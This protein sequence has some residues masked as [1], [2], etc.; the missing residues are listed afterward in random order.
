M[1]SSLPTGRKALLVERPQNFGLR[2]QAHVADFVEEQRA[3]VGLLKLSF[4]VGGGAG[5]RAFAMAEQF[6]LDQVFGNGGAVHFDKHLVLAQA[7]GM[8]G[9][10]DQFFAG[11]R[12][13]VDQHAAVGGR[14]EPNLLA[15]GL[16]GDAVAH[17]HALGL[18]CF[19]R[20][21]FSCR[22]CLASIAFLIRMS[23][24]SRESGFSRKS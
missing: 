8:D 16:H 5:K 10:G 7:L 21:R 19:L 18:S 11:A 23:V 4:L 20:S 22:S 14:H 17:D 24:L 2:L 12:L 13:A 3:A 6:A 15:Q 9:V 1:G